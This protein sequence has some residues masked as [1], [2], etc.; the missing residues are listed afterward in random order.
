MCDD[1]YAEQSEGRHTQRWKC[2]V[3]GEMEEGLNSNSMCMSCMEEY[4][5]YDTCD[6]CG[7]QNYISEDTYHC[8][9]CANAKW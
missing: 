3:C 8:Y 1:C 7:N 6:I 2:K 9:K 5:I 4:T